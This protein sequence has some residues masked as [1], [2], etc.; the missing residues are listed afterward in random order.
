MAAVRFLGK[1][2]ILKIVGDYAWERARLRG[3]TGLDI[4]PYQRSPLPPLLALQRHIRTAYTRAAGMVVTPSRYLAGLV[5]GWGVPRGRIRVVLNGLTPLPDE[6][7]AGETAGQPERGR[8]VVLTAA[9]LVDW[10]G[11]D[12]LIAALP[13]MK[14]PARLRIL[15]QG[16]ERPSLETLAASLGVSPRVEFAGRLSRVRVL[17]EMDRARVFALASGYEGLP[18]V[19]LEAM[20]RSCPVVAAAAGGTP[21]VVEEGVSGLLVPYA[22]PPALARAL[23]R[24]LADDGL[25]RSLGE[26][27][28]RRAREFPWSWTVSQNMDLIKEMLP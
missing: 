17:A 26:A 7:R 5:A 15:G 13:L 25:A 1:P 9:R 11:I 28:R 18:H 3:R 8:R 10:K 16:Q 22:D 4:D 6:T 23:D 27:A 20:S 2:S 21:E 14:Q 12:H 24:V 19:V